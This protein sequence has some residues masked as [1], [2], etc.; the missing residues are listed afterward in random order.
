MRAGD[1]LFEQGHPYDRFYAVL[2]GKVAVVDRRGPDE[3]RVIAVHGPRRFLGEIGLLTG[4]AAQFTALVVEPGEILAVPIGRLA[5]LAVEEPELGDLIV[6]AYLLRRTMLIGLGTG[7]TIVGSRSTPDARRLREF[8]LR[9]RLPH[10]WIDLE[11]DGQAEELLRRLGLTP[12]QTPVVIFGDQVRRNPSTAELAEMLG[13]RAQA[14]P[15]GVCDLVVVGA[16]PAG[17][18]AA[19]YGASEG[20]DTVMVDAVATGGQ[21]AT[22]SRIENYLGFPAGISGSELA[23][24][25][26][27]Q[28][29]KFGARISVPA[30]ARSLT[31][32]DGH[33][34]IGLDDGAEL[35]GRA[36]VIATGAHYRR[37]AVPRLEDFEGT[38]VYYAAT[39]MEAQLCEGDAVAVVG[40]GNSAGQATIFLA[41]FTPRV[42]L[43][44]LHDDLGRDMSRYLADRIER[45][46]N[47]EVR[48]NTAVCE[49]IGD[50]AL[51]ALVVEDARTG[52]RGRVPARALFVFIGADPRTDWLGAEVRL[53]EQGYVLTGLPAA[54]G[55]EP[56]RPLESTLP[57]VF[58]AGD[59]R[60]G[61]IKR[62]SSA[63]GEGAMAVR[64]VHERL[65]TGGHDVA[66]VDAQ[67]NVS[68]T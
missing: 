11:E 61:S 15:R 48:R 60:H 45:A 38:S 55:H 13:L 3:Q 49:L 59:V 28:C 56:G 62:M 47:V 29:R 33:Y 46:P 8:A 18:A 16:G 12:A 67:T 37:L 65:T 36:V 26:T 7:L 40:G 1:V 68:S 64:F 39:W 54:G 31:R 44:V 20:L 2:A 27:V 30:E 24:R 58:A 32:R 35:C 50:R 10:R 52:W 66:A 43:V 21:A 57:G 9:N 53:D 63:V 51:E 6:R 17:L 41:R 23:E 42:T 4:Q 19:V 5:E 22:T 25:A 34:A 14:P